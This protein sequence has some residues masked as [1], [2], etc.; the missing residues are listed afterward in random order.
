MNGDIA[1]IIKE[2]LKNREVFKTLLIGL[3]SEE[4]LWKQNVK[5]WCLLEIICHLYDEERED[6][7]ARTKSV[8]ETPTKTLNPID[9][10]GWVVQRNY[11]KMD[12]DIVLT[13]FLK[14]RRHSVVWLKSLEAPKWDNGYIHPKLGLMTAN[15]FLSNWLAHDYLHIRQITKLKFDYLKKISGEKLNYAG[16]W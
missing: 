6:F 15:L 11:I 8:L 12:Y 13:G 9:P 2:L 16:E 14:E 5:K 4:Y 3:S 7:R 1:Y 10:V